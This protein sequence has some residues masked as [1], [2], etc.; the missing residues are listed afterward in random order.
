MAKKNQNDDQDDSKFDDDDDFGLPDLEYDELEDDD[1]ED[2]DEKPAEEEPVAEEPAAVE[3]PPVSSDDSSEPELDDID[4]EDIDLEDFDAEE[5]NISDEE[6]EKELQELEKSDAIVDDNDDEA[7]P[8]FY[9]EESFD[10]FNSDPVNSVFGADDSDSLPKEEQVLVSGTP[11]EGSKTS[12]YEA[13]NNSS[14]RMTKIII[15]GVVLFTAIALVLWMMIGD[16][17]SEKPVA[18]KEVKK[19][20]PKPKPKP[21]PK[22]EEKP[23]E[24]AVQS[25]PSPAAASSVAAGTVTKLEERTGKAY[26]VIS[27]FFDEDLAMD[28]AN[29]LADEGQSPYVIPPFADHRFWR[30]GIAEYNTMSDAQSQI[31]QYTADFGDDIWPLKY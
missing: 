8:E 6:L 10:D 9:E 29:K 26:V 19:E 14:G 21:Q 22:A 20:Q 28:H 1:F 3:P 31:G 16:P 5:I 25:T 30:V 15:L 4:L 13:T 12:Y 27:S 11:K 23:A 17:S 24:Q 2:E 7:Q 18:E